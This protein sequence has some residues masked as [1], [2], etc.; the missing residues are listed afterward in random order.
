MTSTLLLAWHMTRDEQYLAPIH[1]MAALAL[2]LPPRRLA[3]VKVRAVT[4]AGG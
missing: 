2:E 1:S 4:P 3:V